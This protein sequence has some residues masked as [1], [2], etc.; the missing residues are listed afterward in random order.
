MVVVLEEAVSMLQCCYCCLH[1]CCSDSA[2][3]DRSSSKVFYETVLLQVLT[4]SSTVVALKSVALSMTIT[5]S[6]I[7]GKKKTFLCVYS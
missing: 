3:T 7:N 1:D 5:I 2:D 6:I 4:V